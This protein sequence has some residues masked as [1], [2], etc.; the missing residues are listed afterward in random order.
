MR[1]KRP[2]IFSNF[3]PDKDELSDVLEDLELSVE[4]GGLGNVD[5][6]LDIA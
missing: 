3:K 2:K 1:L 5:F 4:L 6:E